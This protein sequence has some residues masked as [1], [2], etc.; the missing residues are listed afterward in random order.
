MPPPLRAYPPIVPPRWTNQDV[1]LYHGTT[2]A[3]ADGICSGIPVNVSIATVTS[4][5]GR[6]FY[7]SSLF[8]QAATW[9]WQK[10]LRIR[11]ATAAVIEFTIKRDNLSALRSLCFV[12]GGFQVEDYWSFVFYCRM[13]RKSHGRPIQGCYDVVA[14]PVAAFW[15]Q[16][17][18]I[19]D[20]DQ[21][22]F[23]TQDAQDLLNDNTLTKKRVINL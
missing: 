14:G 11:L 1:V 4:D 17:L 16:R 18:A 10:A 7:T 2:K 8:T 12:R 21:I 6:G 9:A 20:V 23:H 5:F 19:L 15:T 3:V 22:S 13:G